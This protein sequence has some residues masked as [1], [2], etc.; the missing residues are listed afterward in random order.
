MINWA[1][2][3][4]AAKGT[5]VARETGWELKGSEEMEMV[6]TQSLQLEKNER[7][8]LRQAAQ[9]STESD[10]TKRTQS[11]AKEDVLKLNLLST[12]DQIVQQNGKSLQ[13]SLDGVLDVSSKLTD[14]EDV[15]SYLSLG[16]P[17]RTI[18]SEDA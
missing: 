7:I 8:N 12:L 9:S 18:G 13:V 14:R 1:E 17:N 3:K 16:F 6:S 11:E 5:L 10:G 15:A 4:A 2:S